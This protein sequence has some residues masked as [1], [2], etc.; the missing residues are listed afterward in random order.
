MA[1]APKQELKAFDVANTNVLS[2]N[3]GTF[4][5]LNA[6]VNGA[7]LYQRVGRKLYMKSLHIRGLISNAATVTQDMMR[8]INF[9][10]LNLTLL[11]VL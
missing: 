1:R 5:L 10:M 9:L 4:T 3:A 7:E 8:I 6:V 11:L 2:S